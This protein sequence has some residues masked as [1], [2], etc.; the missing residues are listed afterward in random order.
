MTG[1]EK[2][3]IQGNGEHPQSWEHP[4]INDAFL[5]LDTA[6]AVNQSEKY[7]DMSTIWEQGV[8]TFV[9]S[10]Q[11]SIA[12][13]W[14]GS[15]AE[16]SKAAIQKY[17]DNDAR[18]LTSGLEE[19]SFRVRDAALAIV[20]TKSALPDPVVVTW[21]SWAWP[22]HRWDMQRDQSAKTEEARTAMT[23]HYV[24][25]FGD[26]DSKIPVLHVPVGPTQSVDIPVP[27]VENPGAS[28]GGG[29]A[30]GGSSGSSGSNAPSGSA[31]QGAQSPEQAETAPSASG[32]SNTQA[33]ASNSNTSST[34]T[35]SSASDPT[36]TVPSSAGTSTSPSGAGVPGSGGSGGSGSRTPGS[37]RSGSGSG[38]SGAGGSGSGG[39]PGAGRSVQGLIGT[40]G[41]TGASTSTAAGT[42]SGARGTGMAGAPGAAGRGGGKDEDST[43]GVPDYLITQENTDELLG[44]IPPTIAGGVIGGE[45][46]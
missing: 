8:E 32:E 45:P 30:A 44:E 23:Q 13:A 3:T 12:Q 9:R 24:K 43:H 2:P 10:I 11:N 22:P 6:D 17:V 33:A 27:K 37:G 38:G 1:Y 36:K 4:K 41:G 18:P 28:A 39:A 42:S 25:P 7:F 20:N 34:S 19:L 21:T 26:L 14:S 35:P 31:A 16:A 15:A 29:G 46:D 40:G 5:P